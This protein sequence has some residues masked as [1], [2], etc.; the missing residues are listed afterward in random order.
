MNRSGMTLDR[1]ED[2]MD[3]QWSDEKKI[4]ASDFII[5]NDEKQPVLPQILSIHQRLIELSEIS[6]KDN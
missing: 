6:S 3:N 2:V 1:I 4:A 5:I